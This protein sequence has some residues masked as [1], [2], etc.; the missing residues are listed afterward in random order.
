MLIETQGE[1][2]GTI[3]IYLKKNELG[4]IIRWF[5]INIH[6]SYLNSGELFGID[7]KY[8]GAFRI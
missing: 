8:Q 4:L 1:G 6:N 2:Q 5:V 3:Y 7:V